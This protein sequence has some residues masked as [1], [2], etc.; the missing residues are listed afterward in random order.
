MA[1]LQEVDVGSL[2][3][4]RFEDIVGSER[5]GEFLGAIEKAQKLFAGRTIYN[6]NSTPRGGGVAE[7]LWSL[8]AYAH[9]A[10]VDARWLVIEGSP[11][12]FRITKRIHNHLHG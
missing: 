2:S 12:F 6:V 5:Y 1:G 4:Y 10:G 8:L 7:M 3:P 9:G 11:E